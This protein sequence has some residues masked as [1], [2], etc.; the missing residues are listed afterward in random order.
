MSCRLSVVGMGVV[1]IVLIWL[2][3]AVSSVQ[4]GDARGG[5]DLGTGGTANNGDKGGQWNEQTGDTV[6]TLV[7]STGR[8]T[9]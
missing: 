4:C 9:G 2:F 1:S 3:S 7:V 6:F 8:G 5:Q